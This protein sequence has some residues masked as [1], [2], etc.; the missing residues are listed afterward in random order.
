M[1]TQTNSKNSQTLNDNKLE[2][3]QNSLLT[4]TD[5]DLDNISSSNK[6]PRD[7]LK[8][9][10]DIDRRQRENKSI[11][12]LNDEAYIKNFRPSN[13][14]SS[15]ILREESARIL[16]R[17]YMSGQSNDSIAP[18][19]AKAIEKN[20][21]PSE[22]IREDYNFVKMVDIAN[23]F[24]LIPR[25]DQYSEDTNSL[26]EIKH[27]AKLT[28]DLVN[29]NNINPEHLKIAKEH[30]IPPSVAMSGN[31]DLT[32]VLEQYEKPQLDTNLDTPVTFKYMGNAEFASTFKDHAK[33]IQD[34]ETNV[35]EV[36]QL[37]RYG[38]LAFESEQDR[39]NTIHSQNI[40]HTA[41]YGIA[42]SI[43]GIVSGANWLLKHSPFD[44]EFGGSRASEYAD[45]SLVFW[46]NIVE[47]M[48]HDVKRTAR[49]GEIV[50][51]KDGGVLP[52]I[53]YLFENYDL[54]L[55][56]LLQE[57]PSM[58]L[59]GRFTAPLKASGGLATGLKA[60]G[61]A[62]LGTYFSNSTKDIADAYS[63][64]N[65]VERAMAE[66]QKK[67]LKT[68][69]VSGMVP[70]LPKLKTGSAMTN[71]LVNSNVNG[72]FTY[73]VG[74][75][76]NGEEVT[77]DGLLTTAILANANGVTTDLAI[78]RT[79]WHSLVR[80]TRSRT[81]DAVANSPFVKNYR[82]EAGALIDEISNGATVHISAET[83]AKQLILK[84]KDPYKLTESIT[85]DG[86]YVDD[87]LITGGYIKF[88][89]GEFLTRVV[90]LV[91]AK[92]LE[93]DIKMSP[94][95]MTYNERM[96]ALQHAEKYLQVQQDQN[97]LGLKTYNKYLATFKKEGMSQQQ[98]E[99]NAFA[100]FSV[101]QTLSKAFES[102]PNEATL[103]Y[104]VRIKEHP[105]ETI[106]GA[107]AEQNNKY[108]INIDKGKKSI[109]LD[110]NSEITFDTYLK[111]TTHL[112]INSLLDKAKTSSSDSALIKEL[113]A[114]RNFLKTDDLSNLTPKDQKRLLGE[115]KNHLN[116]G[117]LT[118]PN[119]KPVFDRY[120]QWTGE[121]YKTIRQLKPNFDTEVEQKLGLLSFMDTAVDVLNAPYVRLFDDAQ[122]ATMSKQEFA[123]YENLQN[124]I[125][126]TTKDK[127][128]HQQF[129]ELT[130]EKIKQWGELK[131]E[132]RKKVILEEEKN[133]IYK[134]RDFLTKGTLKDGSKGQIIKLDEAELVKVYGK[135][136]LKQLPNLTQKNGV[137]LKHV[138]DL[139]DFKSSDDLV[140]ALI[141]STDKNANIEAKTDALMQRDH[142]GLFDRLA[143]IKTLRR[144]MENEDR[145]KVLEFD[146]KLLLKTILEK[147]S[148]A[149]AGYMLDQQILSDG[150]L[151][152]QAKN[153]L[154]GKTIQ[155][156]S[157]DTYLNVMQRES[158]NAAKALK[159]GK[160]D[161]ALQAKRMERF[162]HILYLYSL[163]MI[164]NETKI[165]K[166]INTLN[167]AI[168]L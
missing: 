150:A 157:L 35:K 139:W 6:P 29:Q 27:Q 141:Y 22:L 82:K 124:K 8:D 36:D 33:E 49:I 148:Q 84:G 163:D 25:V 118:D 158:Q 38:D 83:Y 19:I 44:V 31:I 146:E 100:K 110:L 98:A 2:Q 57:G 24:E 69:A 166:V 17:W 10:D 147:D 101:E 21:K 70:W 123:I 168:E 58:Y 37:Y 51:D 128:F 137:S 1:A 90:P 102:N 161:E 56:L 23:R 11:K 117:E 5:Q 152:A 74:N 165:N 133:P 156:E 153:F 99:N 42:K 145:S 16:D 113:Y 96:S 119:L 64:T 4:S 125:K 160:L 13:S 73:G 7:F 86:R 54:T 48:P 114:I 75:F 136:I 109:T 105:L 91:G 120:K 93:N 135:D 39:L 106:K 34:I 81:W 104:S 76:V 45:R 149:V 3:D 66:G 50:A 14:V 79:A 87:A 144:S 15:Q 47:N 59:G 94:N 60:S 129:A 111:D 41:K 92:A 62:F 26:E 115:L 151:R 30:N 18:I 68:S 61:G 121:F 155:N 143:I 53:G 116:T 134:V 107:S 65:D 108:F 78:D 55:N 12:L 138:S 89:K 95:D 9:L 162:N 71:H 130:Q 159:E 167:N 40:F 132:V 88:T 122:Q 142:G 32:K 20:K 85:G 28:L 154:K 97:K 131:K 52:A 127:I 72:A 80:D 164:E 77:M 140:E 103:D 112:Y 43:V 67:T 126:Q 63:R 46:S